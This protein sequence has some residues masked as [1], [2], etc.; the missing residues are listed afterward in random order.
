M[1]HMS[2]LGDSELI[3]NG[4]GSV[5][6]L[7]LLPKQISDVIISVGDPTRV[8][9]VTE[10]FD[11]IDFEMNKRE[12]VTQTGLYRGKKITVM[13]T[14]IGTDNIEIFFNE[15]D[16][17]VNFDFNKRVFKSRKKKLK[18]FRI[19]TSGAIQEDIPIGS[20]VISEYGVGLD[21]VTQFYKLKLSEYE[22]FIGDE[23]EKEVQLPQKPYVVK[24]SEELLEYFRDGYIRGNTVTSPGF[25]APQGRSIRAPSKYPKLL[26][27][28]NYFHADGFWLSNFE[29]ETAGYYA[30][31]RMLGHQVIS[32]NSILA[33]RIKNTFSKNPNRVINSMIKKVLNQIY[34]SGL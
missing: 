24:G 29:M 15:L 26:S 34:E 14:G 17:L 30:F 33:N 10:H 7:N 25:Y 31:G 1:S 23:I 8:F 16:A 20:T 18:I 13:S 19:G 2:P 9:Q 21:S 27:E 22:S 6:H 12:F 5:Y 32:I 3:L 28:L 4:D 11:R